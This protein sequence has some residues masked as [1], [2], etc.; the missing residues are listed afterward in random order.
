MALTIQLVTSLA[1]PILQHIIILRQDSPYVSQVR[2]TNQLGVYQ[3]SFS[4]SAL[5]EKDK[6]KI[7]AEVEAIPSAPTLQ[8]TD[9][10]LKLV[11][12]DVRSHSKWNSKEGSSK[13]SPKHAR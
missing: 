2:F 13:F 6:S 10:L 5:S 9:I 3:P 8:G 12:N 1:S 11:S 7:G 4:L